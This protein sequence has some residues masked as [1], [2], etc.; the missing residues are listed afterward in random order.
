[1]RLQGYDKTPDF[2][3]HV[4]FGQIPPRCQIN[5]MLCDFK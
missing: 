3:M 1:M 5:S 4:P 2:K